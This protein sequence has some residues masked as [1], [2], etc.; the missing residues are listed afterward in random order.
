MARRLWMD[1]RLSL[2]V[3][4]LLLVSLTLTACGGPG[5]I[6]AP[7]PEPITLRFGYRDRTVDILPL[8]EA[9]HAD[10]PWVTIEPVPVERFEQGLDPLVQTGAVDIF[11]DSNAALRYVDQGLLKPLDDLQLADWAPIRDDY[12]EG[13]WDSLRIAGQQWGIPANV[14]TYVAYVNLDQALALH[15]DVPGPDW[16]LFDFLE[17]TNRMNHPEGLPYN[18]SSNLIG[19]CTQPDSLDV[20]LFTYRHGGRIVDSIDSPRIA[21]L[22]D[23]LTI[24][25]VQWYAD[26]YRRYRV[27][28]DPEMVGST[29]RQGGMFE[30]QIRGACG[31]WF[32]LYSSRGGADM[33]FAWSMEYRMLPLPTDRAGFSLGGV[34]GY[35][36]HRDCKHPA[37]AIDL[38]RYLSDR[39]E[40]AGT[41]LPARRSLVASNAYQNAV[42][43]EAGAIGAFFDDSVILLPPEA[44][45]ELEAVGIEFIT[46]VQ[47][48]VWEELDAMGALLEAQDRARAAL[49]GP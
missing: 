14:D 11:L 45:P 23:P 22:D 29:F 15:V 43:E 2:A 32:G 16:S 28:P 35:F 30:A 7:T 47:H 37:E 19:F 31:V 3:A 20:I 10:H 21:T 44:G 9:Y 18:P 48:I 46:A 27:A 4:R 6:I 33:P 38:A 49:G 36:I 1:G 8:F 39:W 25:A 34:E 42:G 17:L 13:V 26:L 5:Q 41:R 40:A 24:E 12:Y